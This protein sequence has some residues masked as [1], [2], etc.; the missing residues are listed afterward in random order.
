M[1]RTII[2]HVHIFKN[3]GT[4]FDSL[5]KNSFGK[6]FVNIDLN[7]ENQPAPKT[8]ELLSYLDA[9]PTIQ[10]LSAHVY[11]Y[12]SL[13]DNYYRILPIIFLREPIRRTFSI[14][15]YYKS[16]REHPSKWFPIAKANDI[17][18]F[19]DIALS[20]TITPGLPIHNFQTSVMSRSNKGGVVTEEDFKLAK[21]RLKQ[22]PMLGIVERFDESIKLIGK[23]IAKYYPKITLDYTKENV[24]MKK[25][26]VTDAKV[27]ERL[28]AANKYDMQL[29][30]LAVK[31]F[32]TRLAKA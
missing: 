19:M 26:V 3:A 11:R 17:N 20:N 22:V 1:R 18:A 2:L 15:N 5:L 13:D 4:S 6:R 30:Q 14:Y 21:Q 8:Q 27:L 31:E 9:N 29:Y 23:T 12:T 32:E 10:A 7:A 16:I 24:S 25:D 28:K